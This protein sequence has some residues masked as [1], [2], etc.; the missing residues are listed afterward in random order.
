VNTPGPLGEPEGVTTATGPETCGVNVT[1]IVAGGALT[2]PLFRTSRTIAAPW[3]STEPWAEASG[4][5]RTTSKTS[6]QMLDR[7]SWLGPQGTTLASG[8]EPASGL[9]T[10]ASGSDPVSGLATLPSEVKPL[11]GVG[12]LVSGRDPVS[13]VG[14]LVSG[15]DPVSG[16]GTLASGSAP[17][18]GAGTPTSAVEG[19]VS[20][21]GSEPTSGDSAAS[22]P[23]VCA[24]WIVGAASTPGGRVKTHTPR[25]HVSEGRQ[26]SPTVQS[27]P[28]SPVGQPVSARRDARRSLGSRG[29]G[30][31][32]DAG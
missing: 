16:A 8:S 10:P 15:R 4:E 18:S 23:G 27:S 28:P 11:S 9:G 12:T 14:T 20:A 21:R 13:G 6:V 26:S 29:M 31:P 7:R 3:A 2:V 5:S 30:A 25:S 1:V 24:S 32:R 22:G 19:P 17:V